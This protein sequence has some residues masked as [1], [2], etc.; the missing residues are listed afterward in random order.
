MTT[1]EFIKL[2]LFIVA[3]PVLLIVIFAI[4]Q[5]DKDKRQSEGLPPKKYHSIVDEDVT[6]VYTIH[7][8]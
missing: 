6:T 8:D 3:L 1:W 2:I 5:R 4:Q 7:R